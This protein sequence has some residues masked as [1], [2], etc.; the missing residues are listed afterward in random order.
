MC[1]LYVSC[2]SKVSPRTFGCVAVVKCP[3]FSYILQG[4]E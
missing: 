4:M 1:V 3:D 2:G